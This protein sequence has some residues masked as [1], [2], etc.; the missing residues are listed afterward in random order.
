MPKKVIRIRPFTFDTY[1]EYESINLLRE[2]AESCLNIT[3][4][5]F[6]EITKI[7]TTKS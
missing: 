1:T 2:M 3:L 6:R 7:F 4:R 5:G